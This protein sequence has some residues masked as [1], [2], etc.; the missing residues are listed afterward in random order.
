ML[1]AS[2]NNAVNWLIILW[3]NFLYHSQENNANERIMH[4][5]DV[6]TVN[7]T[8]LLFPMHATAMKRIR[9]DK[10]IGIVSAPRCSRKRFDCGIT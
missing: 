2:M 9:C 10:Y 8:L 5:L 1:Y 6:E 4:K 3:N 7:R